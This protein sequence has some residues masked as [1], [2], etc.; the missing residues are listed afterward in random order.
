MNHNNFVRPWFSTSR[1]YS[2]VLVLKNPHLVFF[3]WGGK[4][5]DVRS[6]RVDVFVQ[7]QKDSLTFRPTHTVCPLCV[8]CVFVVCGGC[9]RSTQTGSCVCVCVCAA[10][11]EDMT[12][13][14]REGRLDLGR[15]IELKFSLQSETGARG[16]GQ[17]ELQGNDSV[18][19]CCWAAVQFYLVVQ[20]RTRGS[21][22]RCWD[23]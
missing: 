1:L 21:C 12:G 16:E 22:N 19:K 17:E 10:V 11:W 6:E 2:S 23:F 5:E 4:K 7:Q 14:C 13:Q 9:V 20:N 8:C 18:A 15:L 3:T